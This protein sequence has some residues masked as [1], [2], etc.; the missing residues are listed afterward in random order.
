MT[1]NNSINNQTINVTIKKFTSNDT[2]TKPANLQYAFIVCWS[3]GNG[4]GSGRRGASTLSAGGAVGCCSNVIFTYLPSYILNSTET[5][6][7]GAG[8]LG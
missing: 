7:V 4:G 6:T 8:G 3:G 2:W 5:V 1:Q